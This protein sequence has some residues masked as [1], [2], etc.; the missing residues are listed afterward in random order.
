MGTEEFRKKAGNDKGTE[1]T[2]EALKK[3]KI[4]AI[5]KVI[6]QSNLPKPDKEEL[7]RILNE[8]KLKE[9]ISYLEGLKKWR[10]GNEKMINQIIEMI[11][12]II[13]TLEETENE[14]LNQVKADVADF[15]R[16]RGYRGGS[17]EISDKI[18]KAQSV[19]E[20]YDI[21][22]SYGLYEQYLNWLKK[23]QE[24]K[25]R[26]EEKPSAPQTGLRDR[27]LAEQKKEQEKERK[28]AI[29]GGE[30]KEGKPETRNYAG[31]PSEFFD[32]A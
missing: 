32:K 14:G 18:N 22:K 31:E 21:L 6:N 4:S 8:G 19:G 23:K 25:K 1:N 29:K 15:L 20:I 11:N 27:T 2:A 16:Y 26:Q 13:D 28:K 5:E 9:V 17:E 7:T 10:V 12:Q 3:T 30:E 24:D